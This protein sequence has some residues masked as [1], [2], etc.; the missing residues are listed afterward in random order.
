MNINIL[1]IV[2]WCILMDIITSL[3]SIFILSQYKDVFLENFWFSFQYSL[4][5][6][7]SL[8]NV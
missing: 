5:P 6:L 2:I 7:P 1:I 3:F 8:K 4:I